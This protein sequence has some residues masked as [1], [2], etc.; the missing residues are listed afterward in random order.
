MARVDL[1]IV[2]RGVKGTKWVAE[3]VCLTPE[4]LDEVIEQ[5]TDNTTALNSLP[6]P[7]ARFFVAREAFRRVKEE[8]INPAKEAGVA[9]RQLVSDILDIY[10]L[11]FYS[12]Y[13]KNIWGPEGSKI[14]IREWDYKENLKPLKDKMPV[15]YNS[16]YE[17]YSTDIGEDALH[18]LVFTENGHDILLGCTSPYTGFITPPD[19]DKHRG[20]DDKDK[21][22]NGEQ[23]ENLHI[24]RK[25]GGEYFLD[26]KLFE[27]RGKDFKNYMYN[28][29]FGSEA[30]NGRMKEI[31]EYIR[32]FKN[33]PDIRNDYS[34]TLKSA[35]TDQNQELVV[36]GLPLMTN[37]EIDFNSYFT[38]YIIR[39]PYK[40]ATGRFKT[41]RYSKDVA[42]RE[43]DY[44]LPFK[45]EVLSLYN[46]G[47]IDSDVKINRDSITVTLRCRG[48]EYKKEYAIT[49]CKQN[50]GRI[51]DLKEGKVDFDF[52][53]FPNI[54]SSKEK[55][56][57]Y[58]KVM[59][60]GSEDFRLRF[61]K[62]GNEI[63]EHDPKT[64]GVKFGVC[65]V[66]VR[67]TTKVD[68]REIKTLFYEIYNTSF[69]AIEVRVGEYS[70]L[71]FPIFE[72]STISNE[73]YTYAID[74]GTTNT[75]ISR[76]K[77]GENNMP[78]MFKMEKPMVSYL[79]QEPQD[80]QVA[81]SYR[82]ENSIFTDGCNK[83]KTE[84]APAF[85]D[86][87]AY[88]FPIRTAICGPEKKVNYPSLFDDHNIAFFYEKMRPEE[89]QKIITNIKWDKED[90]QLKLFVQELLLMIKSD[91]LQ[92]NGDLAMTKLIWFRPLSFMGNM[93]T[94]YQD[95]WRTE[96]EKVLGIGED[97]ISC[98][99][100]SEAP[101]YYFKKKDYIKDTE[102]VTVIDIGGG[103]TDFVYFENNQPKMA[104]SVH[105]GCDVIWGNGYKEFE[106]ERENGIYRH[107][108][109]TLHFEQPDLEL[110]NKEFKENKTTTKD[111]INFWLSNQENGKMKKMMAIEYKPV[112]VY[113][114]T[115][116][117]Y[118]MACMYKDN[119]LKAPHSVIFSGNGSR[120]VDDFICRDPKVI[121]KVIELVFEKVYGQS[122]VVKLELPRERKEPTCYGGLYRD[123]NAPDV[124]EVIYH[125]VATQ[126]DCK[127]GEIS[128]NLSKHS[129]VLGKKY[130]EL[131]DLYCNAL[132][133][134]RR[135]GVLDASI[136]TNRFVD[137]VRKDMSTPLKT[138][139]QS[140]V[141]EAYSDED[142]LRD[143]VF[144]IPVVDRVFEL[145]KM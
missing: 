33:D 48:Q 141:K 96:P 3:D 117:L 106:D 27:S 121:K 77:N 36:N 75:F 131:A 45:P 19:L 136:N 95:I 142:I 35:L 119:G 102:S 58:F 49:P 130:S 118:Y 86:G 5:R 109:D 9:Y 134:L 51:V 115:A 31:K 70:G 81:L 143:S 108:A 25:S 144:F 20:K 17:Y 82:I 125:G 88:K 98:Y 14:E 4:H 139:Y 63:K 2:D 128:A 23:Y 110:L 100:E 10:E 37:D 80:T 62:D 44:L 94:I 140:Q 16:L 18:F 84:F 103:S 22:F 8:K 92:R 38:P 107:Y 7:F 137:C 114:L 101:Y 29:V 74:L 32:T 113:H 145:T 97:S 13:H 42:N 124:P 127:I 66:V 28:Y 83:I 47:E 24:H 93:R 60:L 39:L 104:N 71:V 53:L 46:N 52:G 85:V 40:I 59:V 67:S 116:L 79:H 135:E 105:F 57:N 132:E 12:K 64:P 30:I 129:I 68:Q 112:F 50:M 126:S 76:S 120:Y 138:Y 6:T 34:L 69:N 111:I 89:G 41:V 61:F 1:N 26:I 43:Y 91:I 133:L 11:I 55:E 21:V 123:S 73:S 65:P 78:E 54:L 72:H 56:N 99:S 15:L 87:E 122:P 90:A